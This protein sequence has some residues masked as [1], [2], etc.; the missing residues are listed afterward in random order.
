MVYPTVSIPDVAIP[1]AIKKDQSLYS[2]ITYVQGSSTTYQN[3]L[4]VTTEVQQLSKTVTQYKVVMEVKEKKE[5]LVVIYNS[6]TK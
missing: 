1:T 2:V 3:V 5:Q 4:P 6:E